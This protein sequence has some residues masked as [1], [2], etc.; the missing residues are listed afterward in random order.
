MSLRNT[1][2]ELR[3][4]AGHTQEALAAK[5]GVTRQS[6][7]SIE[8]G[9]YNP[10]LELALQIARLFETTVEEVFLLDDPKPANAVADQ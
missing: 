8:T 1:V 9:K 2:R 7:I 4:A 5:L 6:V 3:E 10:S